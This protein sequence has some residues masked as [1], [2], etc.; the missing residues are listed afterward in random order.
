MAQTSSN[1]KSLAS[2]RRELIRLGNPLRA[3]KSLRFFKTA[4][5][6]YGAGDRFRGITMPELRA[7]AQEYQSLPSENLIS[8][9]QSPWH[10]DRLFVLI[11]ATQTAKTDHKNLSHPLKGKAA[12]ESLNHLYELYRNNFEGVNNWDLVDASAEFLLGAPLLARGK[13][14]AW[15]DLQPWVKSPALWRRRAAMV[16]SLH[17]TRQGATDFAFRLGEKLLHDSEDL[18]QKAVGWMLREAGKKDLQKLEAFLDKYAASM[19]RTSLRY[20]LEKFP[21]NQKRFYMQARLAKS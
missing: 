21:E 11:H 16:S 4:P 17:F 9:L 13:I 5:G 1:Q 7:L 19:P 3:E 6:D 20:A 8:L 15:N 12:R 2:L 14:Q 10:E 18:I